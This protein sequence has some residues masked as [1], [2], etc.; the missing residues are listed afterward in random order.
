LTF[1]GQAQFHLFGSAVTA[2]I[3]VAVLPGP[4]AVEQLRKAHLMAAVAKGA[5]Y[6]FNLDSTGKLMPVISNCVAKIKASGMASAADFSNLPAP[7]KTAAKPVV[8]SAAEPTTKPAKAPKT[9]EMNGTGFVISTDGYVLTNYHVIGNCESDIHGNLT[10]QS[11]T[12]LRVVSKDETNDLA[13]LQAPTTSKE[14]APIRA[15]A[16]RSGEP[17]IAIGYP[18][19]GLLT[20]DFT[21]T[22]GIVSS[23]SGIFND[24]RY[25]QISA[26]V[27]PGNSGGPLLDAAG[28]VVGVVA[29]KLATLKFVKATGE[30]PENIS[31]AI[32][33]GAVR[34]FLDNSVVSYRTA[35]SKV[36]LKTVDIA[37]NARAYTMLISCTGK[38]KE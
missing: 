32:K 12:T 8:Q 37:Q 5:T 38:E 33:T 4:A 27:Q 2:Q 17:V 1:D 22:T 30:I 14:I 34:D 31:F 18:Y 21:V 10:S 24:T 35:D 19:H 6:Q 9:I 13:L 25:L 15:T 36:E 26:A 7:P 16:V 29:E 23:L 3:V 20:S 28:N 11:A